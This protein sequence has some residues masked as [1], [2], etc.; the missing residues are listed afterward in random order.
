[1][2]ILSFK[3]NDTNEVYKLD[4]PEGYTQNDINTAYY[5]EKERRKQEENV[6]PVV[7]EV[8]APTINVTPD[9]TEVKEEEEEGGLTIGGAATELSIAMAGNVAA[10]TTATALSFAPP[11][12]AVSYFAINA[13][14]GWAGSYA[15]QV[16]EGGELSYGEMAAGAVV[17]MWGP[18]GKVL[19]GINAS[20]KLTLPLVFEGMKAGTKHGIAVGALYPNVS[21]VIDTGKLA[22]EED[23]LDSVVVNGLVG[24]IFSSI[25]PFIKK[26]FSKFF[27]KTP[28][29][30]DIEIANGKIS[31]ADLSKFESTLKKEVTQASLFQDELKKLSIDKRNQVGPVKPVFRND[32]INETTSMNI[33]DTPLIIPKSQEEWLA[34]SIYLNQSKKPLSFV[35]PPEQKEMFVSPEGLLEVNPQLRRKVVSVQD[36]LLTMESVGVFN[37]AL[38]TDETLGSVFDKQISWL[39][40]SVVTG[41][42]PQDEMFFAQQSIEATKEQGGKIFNQIDKIVTKQPALKEELNKFL[43]YGAITPTLRDN[44]KLLTLANQWVDTVKPLQDALLQQTSIHKTSSMDWDVQLQF[45]KDVSKSIEQRGFYTTDEYRSMVDEGFKFDPKLKQKAINAEI[46]HAKKLAAEKGSPISA[47][48]ARA[49]AEQ[50]IEGLIKTSN[51]VRNVVRQQGKDVNTISKSIGIMQQTL[52][53]TPQTRDFLGLIKDPAAR[54]R[55]TVESLS[56]L[57][58][59][60]Q[61]DIGIID[62]LKA[63]DLAVVD[64]PN[65]NNFGELKL[66]SDIDTSGLYVPHVVQTALNE[67]ILSEAMYI[68][69]SIYGKATQ[70]LW[71]GGIAT[72]KG[73]RVLANPA[74]YMVN[75]YG[76]WSTIMSA[77]ILPTPRNI[78]TY[79]QGMHLGFTKQI[80][81]EVLTLKK[82]GIL[83]NSAVVDDIRTIGNSGPVSK[84]VSDS[85][86]FLGRVYSTTDQAARYT[87]YKVYKERLGKMFPTESEENIIRGAALQA[88]D[89][90]QLYTTL[91]KKYKAASQAGALPAFA[92]FFGALVRNHYH[93]T[94]NNSRMIFGTFGKE[95]GLDPT[96]ASKNRMKVEGVARQVS[97]IGMIAGTLALADSIGNV[98]KEKY[99]AIKS[100]VPDW[101]KNKKLVVDFDPVTGKYRTN[102][103]EYYVP[104]LV[105]SSA[106]EGALDDNKSLGD[107]T[108]NFFSVIGDNLSPVGSPIMRLIF[109]SI[110]NRDENGNPISTE[111]EILDRA[112]D[113]AYRFTSETITPAGLKA[114]DKQLDQDKSVKSLLLNWARGARPK[115]YDIKD[116]A[117]FTLRKTSEI[118]REVKSDYTSKR[119]YDKNATALTINDTYNKVSANHKKYFGDAIKYNKDLEKLDQSFDVRLEILTNAG[120]SLFDAAHVLE[121]KYNP[122]PRNK[123]QT[124]TTI[125]EDNYSSLTEK[126]FYSKLYK[127]KTISLGMKGDIRDIFNK[128][129][130]KDYQNLSGTEDLFSRF[131]TEQQVAW[132]RSNPELINEYFNKRILSNK[133][134]RKIQGELQSN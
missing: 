132:L 126:E 86:E 2:S 93:Q 100:F 57:V 118:M 56:S 42:G 77:G 70:D 44:P 61:L 128:Q 41:R 14:S 5:A 130:I 88:L 1:M 55:G 65:D 52:D 74:S 37:R 34:K 25:T 47:D 82:L 75:A 111:Y 62:F 84:K 109:S 85:F 73:V 9:G 95:Y 32:V 20:T 53:L 36:N 63:K 19:Q 58:Y 108:K 120:F 15:R 40:P 79:V 11:V 99:E 115:D 50:R 60:Q 87:M 91:N 66:Y 107:V 54:M 69:N 39:I 117:Y 124:A 38:N 45:N 102:N 46:V 29:E 17:N 97:Q 43:E 101:D 48:K 122:I 121:G 125:W 96:K 81:D 72:W 21:S 83:S 4:L 8:V 105:F 90:M 67:S 35:K 89:E 51:Q 134:Y 131:T 59:K 33:D 31:L 110:D 18:A 3:D 23:T 104:Q 113:Y 123:P 71:K 112:K 94:K 114:L 27:N 26:N 13:A 24:G 116:T 64:K 10:S 92:S 6:T 49:V 133:A 106:I 119:D 127:D 30:I 78:F 16:Q 129:S 103:I 98:T 12:A 80:K 7:T 68:P 22:S 76:G 28:T